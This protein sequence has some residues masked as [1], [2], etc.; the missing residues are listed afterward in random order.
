MKYNQNLKKLILGIIN[1]MKNKK[2]IRFLGE[3]TTNIIIAVIV[4]ILLFYAGSKAY[5]LFQDK[6]ELEKAEGNLNNFVIEFNNF[7]NTNDK[8]E[9]EF[10]ILGPEDWYIKFFNNKEGGYSPKSCEGYNYC[11]CFCNGDTVEKC[12]NQG[13]CFEL[14][15]EWKWGESYEIDE[16]PYLI[17][18]TK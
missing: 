5:G 7:M 18:I 6:S 10:M 1:K 15:Y 3:H 2:A 11:V 4:L 16:I 13:A 17:K 9:T 14:K 8:N 12:N